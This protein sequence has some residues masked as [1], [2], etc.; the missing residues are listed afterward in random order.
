MLVLAAD[1]LGRPELRHEAEA[2]GSR[3]LDRFET[4]G[5]PWPCGI[6]NAGEA[7]NLLLGLAGIGYFFLRLYDSESLPTVLLPAAHSEPIQ[8]NRISNLRQNLGEKAVTQ[9][10]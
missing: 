5:M 6:P 2:A 4:V 3:A 9:C 8:G 10:G 1:L 7:P